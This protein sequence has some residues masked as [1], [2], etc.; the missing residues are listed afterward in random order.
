MEAMILA[1]GEGRRLLPLTRDTPK[2]LVDVAGRTALARVFNALVGAGADH[3]VVNAHH[4]GALVEQAA[5]KLAHEGVRVTVSREDLE[6]AAPLDTGGALAFARE[7]LD[8]KAPFF[9]HNADILTDLP[10]DRV[11]RAHQAD[12]RDR[13]AT[14][15][16]TR[17][18]TSRPLVV[19]GGRVRGDPC[20][21]ATHTQFLP[22][23]RDLLDHRR[24]HAAGRG[25]RADR[26]LRCYGLRLARYRDS[27]TA[28][29]GPTG[30]PCR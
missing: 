15:V 29:S 18:E 20:D 17:R 24:L 30:S 19:D 25:G 13:L 9:L 2:A 5:L 3:I 11:Y 10:L 27:G 14:L 4:H 7:S 21:L 12:E 23:A 8:A 16:V 26:L 22:E 28:R 1:A 6:H